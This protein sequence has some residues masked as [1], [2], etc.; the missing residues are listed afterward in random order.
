M[1]FKNKVDPMKLLQLQI[2]DT[3]DR[4]ALLL[5]DKWP[6]IKTLL[7]CLEAK[8]NLQ[9]NL[10]KL[11]VCRDQG[12][13]HPGE[14][15]HLEGPE[16]E[17]PLE[18]VAADVALLLTIELVLL[19]LTAGLKPRSALPHTLLK[20]IA[21]VRD[22]KIVQDIE[23]NLHTESKGLPTPLVGIDLTLSTRD[24][25]QCEC[26]PQTQVD[27]D[28][29]NMILMP[30]CL[31]DLLKLL[32]IEKLDVIKID[33]HSLSDS[34]QDHAHV[35]ANLLRDL[36]KILMLPMLLKLLMDKNEVFNFSLDLLFN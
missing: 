15:Q 23:K 9:P 5:I 10:K 22:T 17:D 18:A 1:Q 33:Q 30:L 14:D 2:Q 34:D 29:Y 11:Q 19:N 3:T 4:H 8:P 25:M 13:Q 21:N 20:D 7:P 27:G 36:T 12:D 28:K 26:R 24:P 32:I 6:N 35:K 16:K 31:P